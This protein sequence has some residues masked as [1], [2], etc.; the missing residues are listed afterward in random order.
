MF[1][2]AVDAAFVAK[3]LILS[4]LPSYSVILAFSSVFSQDHLVSGIFFSNSVLSLSYL[5][6][7][8]NTLV[9]ILFTLTTNIS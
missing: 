6:Y 9:S 5:V 8:T 2:T 4:I 1:S 3:P 7:K